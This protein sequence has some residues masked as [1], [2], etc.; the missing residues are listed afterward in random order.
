MSGTPGKRKPRL[1]R[2][3][4]RRPLRLPLS[5]LILAGLL[6]VFSLVRPSRAPA[7][8][9]PANVALPP[10]TSFPTRPPRPTDVHGGRI[11]FTCTR[12]EINQICIIRAD[13][14]GYAQLTSGSSNS[15]YPAISHDGSDVVY[16]V[17]Q[18]DGFDLYRLIPDAVGGPRETRSRLK[19][20]TD[21]VGNAFSPSFSPDGRQIL[22]VNKVE[23]QP[24]AIWLMG[25]NGEDPHPIYSPS[26]NV[27]GATWSPDGTRVAFTMAAEASFR[28]EIYVLDLGDTTA[29]PRKVPSQIADIGGSLS[30]SP[31]QSHLLI[32]AGPAAAREIFSLDLANGAATQLTFGGN[33]AS[34]SYSPD[35]SQIV[36]NSLRNGGQADLYIMLADGHSMRRLTDNPEPDW[37]PQWGP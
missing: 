21:Y 25:R 22:F 28:Y 5:L 24:A 11:V 1:F 37:Q 14:S 13:G 36:F 29:L 3:A 16:A 12:S 10:P 27:V 35:G 19:R 15:Y 7:N 30:W 34:A 20:L 4:A 8:V 17:N 26:R 18:Y 32:F 6:A 23:D 33:N 2:R 9:N 31:D